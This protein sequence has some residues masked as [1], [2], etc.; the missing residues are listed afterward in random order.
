MG[1]VRPILFAYYGKYIVSINI[2]NI[3]KNTLH[4]GKIY[5]SPT[6]I[7]RTLLDYIFIFHN[8]YVLYFTDRFCVSIPLRYYTKF[9]KTSGEYLNHST[10]I[11]C[12][13]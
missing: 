4:T 11:I 6:N 5:V 8:I 7:K 13:Y 1:N 2:L 9:E 10:K 12:P 3:P